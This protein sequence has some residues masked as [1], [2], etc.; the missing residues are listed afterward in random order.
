[1]NPRGLGGP[2][3]FVVVTS[4]ANTAH[5]ARFDHVERPERIE[6]ALAG[7]R[8]LV[9]AGTAE[10]VTA[11]AL[12]E[13]A[14]LTVHSESHVERVRRA[15]VASAPLDPDTYATPAS[16]KAALLAAGAAVEAAER[17]AEGTPA[18][19]IARPPGHHATRD[20]AMGFCLFNNV[21]L[22]AQR[23]TE[24]GRRVAIVDI[25][26]HHGNGTQD[27]FYD[28]D[29]VLYVSLHQWP[30][31]PGTGAADETGAGKGEGFT[32]NLP[33]PPG[34]T[35]EAWMDVFRRGALPTIEAFAP[36]VVLVSAGFDGHARDPLGG[37]RLTAATYHDAVSDLVAI[38]PRV[39]A[40]LE[41]GYDLTAVEHCS[42]AVGAA[43]MGNRGPPRGV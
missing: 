8:P 7:V 5:R 21:A 33:V 32:V 25:D 13:A 12:D 29:D 16:W 28:R 31:Y 36:D 42:A 41:G 30:L 17:A 38:V 39:A 15:C 40:V 27:I 9:E 11:T 14:L 23:L 24:G 26:V 22:A 20:R 2:V 19:A 43:L 37:L 35:H 3:A 34:T 4:G 10:L 18:F 6:A 1:M